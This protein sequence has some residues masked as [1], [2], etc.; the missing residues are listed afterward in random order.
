M[1]IFQFQV[2][3]NFVLPDANTKRAKSVKFVLVG[4]FFFNILR[5][6]YN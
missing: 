2:T 4:V 1:V 6:S 3:S 5:V